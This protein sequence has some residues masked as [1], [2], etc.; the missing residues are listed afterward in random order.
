MTMHAAADIIWLV[1]AVMVTL[2]LDFLSR[3]FGSGRLRRHRQGTARIYSANTPEGGRVPFGLGARLAAAWPC[4][5]LHVTHG[6][7]H[8]RI[9]RDEGVITASVDFLMA[10]SG[11]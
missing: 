2:A 3:R 4:A 5:R 9:L 6:L 8:H 7:G 10:G 11:C 1:G